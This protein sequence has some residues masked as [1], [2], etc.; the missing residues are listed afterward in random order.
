MKKLI[1]SIAFAM[2]ATG[3]FA[4]Y[5]VYWEIDGAH[6]MYTNQSIEFD[7]ATISTVDSSGVKTELYQCDA[8]GVKSEYTRM[9]SAEDDKTSTDAAVYSGP[10]SLD[11]IDYYSIGLYSMTDELLGWKNV[12]MSEMVSHYWES[13]IEG[14]GGGSPLKVSAVVPEPTSALMMLLGL[15]ALALK[16]PARRKLDVV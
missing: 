16:R 12:S 9:Y 13:G 7:Y 4:D 3:A 15:A 2:V 6:D 8:N 5:L 1:S 11:N 10:V 14:H